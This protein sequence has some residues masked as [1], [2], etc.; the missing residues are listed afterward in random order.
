MVPSLSRRKISPFLNSK[1]IVAKAQRAALS[2][3]RTPDTQS[4]AIR[5]IIPWESLKPVQGSE[6]LDQDKIGPRLLGRI[7]NTR[8][9]HG[10]SREISHQKN[11]ADQFPLRFSLA[12]SLRARPEARPAFRAIS[13]LGS[14]NAS[15]S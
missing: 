3:N 2:A 15:P 14:F 10:I 6:A 1:T 7:L 8:A 11:L 4:A 13:R 5:K 9:D 12:F